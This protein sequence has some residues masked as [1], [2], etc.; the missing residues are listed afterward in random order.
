MDERISVAD[1][2]VRHQTP[3]SGWSHPGLDAAFSS[4]G[5]RPIPVPSWLRACCPP[6]TE[7][8][9]AGG[10]SKSHTPVLHPSK[11]SPPSP[12][13][14]HAEIPPFNS[15]L[16]GISHRA[17]KTLTSKP[18]ALSWTSASINCFHSLHTERV[19]SSPC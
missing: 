14:T 2:S 5:C 7:G 17:K 6:L 19:C 15:S 8:S 1:C 9:R 3:S 13:L 10:G 18:S 4:G 11:I 12:F 16:H